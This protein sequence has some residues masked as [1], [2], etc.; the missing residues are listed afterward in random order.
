[1]KH[2]F[3]WSIFLRGIAMGSA[4]VVPGVSGGTIAFITG[5][6]EELILTIKNLEFSQVKVLFKDGFTAFWKSIN[7]TFLFSLIS[8]ILLSIFSLAK[9][10]TYLL[11]NHSI[12]LFAFFFGLILASAVYI[13][14][15]IKTW[16]WKHILILIVFSVIAFF[17]TTIT[18]AGGSSSTLYLFIC[19]AIAICAMILPGISG[20]FILLLLG[21]YS[22]IISSLKN[23]DFS[24]IL[25]VGAGA[26]I[27]ILFFSRILA[28]L[29]N[30]FKTMTLA[31]LT[32][33]VLGALNKVWPWKE[34]LET[35][36]DSHGNIQPLV[37]KS[38]TPTTYSSITGDP[39]LMWPSLIL[40]IVGFSIVFI[41][42]RFANE[43]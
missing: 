18:P 34:V 25:P 33:F 41:L 1:M 22:L 40:A 11:E 30:N 4:D 2:F 19:G 21:Q 27:G 28:W 23:M 3:R 17:I 13:G 9:I 15:Q 10:I 12:L 8:G 32:G 39:H 5:I 29:F 43:K 16:D 20:S 24:V 37:E 26:I 35:Y 31:G 36:T 6:Y 7:G 42:E 38:I 14:K